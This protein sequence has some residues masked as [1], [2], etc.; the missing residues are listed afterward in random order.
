[1]LRIEWLIACKAAE[2]TNENTLNLTGAGIDR[3]QVESFPAV[4]T[5]ML[6]LRIVGAAEEYGSAHK[7]R[8]V[9]FAPD[10]SELNRADGELVVERQGPEVDWLIPIHTTISVAIPAAVRGAYR[11]QVCTDDTDAAE[12]T[13]FV[14]DEPPDGRP[15]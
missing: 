15:Y 7:L 9:L 12:L 11:V 13:L 3:L 14:S 5:C 1:V 6:A 10:G 8:T 2:R 4:T